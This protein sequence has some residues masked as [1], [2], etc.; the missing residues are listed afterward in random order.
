MA[1]P[2]AEPAR[3]DLT[4]DLVGGGPPAPDDHPDT[5]RQGDLVLP[6][7]YR[8]APG[9]PLDGVTVHVPLTALNQL[10]ADG[11]DWQV[12]GYRRELV[13]ALVRTLPKELRRA[14]IPAAE[15]TGAACERLGPP[16]G[17]LVDALAAALLAGVA[18][19][20]SAFRPATS[21]STCACT[22]W[23]A[24]PTAPCSTPTTISIPSG[25]AGR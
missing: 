8:Y 3:L 24:T 13:G 20:A 5:W 11:F 15:T 22:S 17:R 2:R 18:I 19:P 4:D 23:S 7:T 12:T 6:L 16:R 10:T 21:P 14:L 9:R 1:R 25:P